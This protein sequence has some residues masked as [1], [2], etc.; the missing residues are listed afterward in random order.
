MKTLLDT[1]NRGIVQIDDIQL[2]NIDE[3]D[4]E[5][6][7]KQAVLLNQSEGMWVKLPIIREVGIDNYEVID[8]HQ[9]V[10]AAQKMQKTNPQRETLVAIITREYKL[11]YDADKPRQSEQ[12]KLIAQMLK[13]ESEAQ[14]APAKLSKEEKALLISKLA[15]ELAAECSVL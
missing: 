11:K 5:L 2:K 1:H 12:E 4:H 7:V 14:P 3:L 15:A 6:A 13:L 10:L 8:G 9:I